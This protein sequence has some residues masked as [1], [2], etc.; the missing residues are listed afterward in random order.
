[1]LINFLIYKINLKMEKENNKSKEILL[2]LNK[3]KEENYKFT[4]LLIKRHFLINSF[5]YIINL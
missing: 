5:K 2:L 4:P 1:M 3:I